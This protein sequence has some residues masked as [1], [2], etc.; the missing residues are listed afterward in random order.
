MATAEAETSHNERVPPG[1]IGLL[2]QPQ[3]ARK[4]RYVRHRIDTETSSKGRFDS[5]RLREEEDSRMTGLS[6]RSSSSW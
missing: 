6:G 4:C 5:R 3:A 1:G 2:A